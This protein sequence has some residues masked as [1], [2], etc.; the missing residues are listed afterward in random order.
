M[1]YAHIP[2]SFFVRRVAPATFALLLLILTLSAPPPSRAQTQQSAPP[3]QSP[4]ENTQPAPIEPSVFPEGSVISEIRVIDSKGVAVK[5]QIPVL[6]L[7]PGKPFDYDEER[8][9]LRELY[10]TGDYA[11]IQVN[12]VPVPGNEARIDF[13]VQHNFY[14]NVVRVFGVKEPP[15]EAAALAAMRLSLGEPFRESS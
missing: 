7:V 6:A 9:S 14:N 12:A 13:V 3:P 10:R 5:A 2:A 8:E 4:A 15:S 1:R 11:D